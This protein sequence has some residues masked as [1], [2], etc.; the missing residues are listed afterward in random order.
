MEVLLEL[1]RKVDNLRH[2]REDQE[3]LGLIVEEEAV[4]VD[5]SLDFESLVEEVEVEAIMQMPKE[6][7]EADLVVV[8]EPRCIQ[9]H[10]NS[11]EAV[12]VEHRE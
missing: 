2:L 9:V 1:L 10:R 11:E 7:L 12:V 6:H 8:A 5:M 4:V 3:V